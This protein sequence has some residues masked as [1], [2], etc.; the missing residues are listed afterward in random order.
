M[1]MVYR[2]TGSK[3][4]SFGSRAST[5]RIAPRRKVKRTVTFTGAPTIEQRVARAISRSAETKQV[6]WY[7]GPLY[8]GTYGNQ[9]YQ[10]HNCQ[11][12]SNPTDILRLIPYLTTGVLD[13][14]RIG[15]K[16][17]PKSLIVNGSLRLSDSV[18]GQTDAQFREDI[19]AV[20]YVL[21]H[22][23]LKSYVTLGNANDFNQLL[24]TGENT[25]T[26]FLGSAVQSQMPVEDAYYRLLSKKKIRLR[27][28]GAIPG[29]ATGVPVNA[30]VSVANAHSYYAD[31]KFNLSK[32]LPKQ[33]KYPE[34]P[35]TIAGSSDPTN[36]SI[37]MC[38]GFYN[39]DGS[40]PPLT[41][42]MEIQYVSQLKFKDM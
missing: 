34:T 19:V 21:Q 29:S 31:F 5:V 37:F 41:Q 22:V 12:L 18:I 11:I 32:H 16:V 23:T 28:A 3:A 8:N 36:S 14:N 25:T 4:R 33:F 15:E 9:G 1:V 27:Y 24:R 42:T 6:A 20:I 38:V 7:S 2:K 13:N 30:Y 26:P 35:V 17:S 39:M 10:T 40:L